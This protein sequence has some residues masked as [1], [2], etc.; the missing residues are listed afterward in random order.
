MTKLS[1]AFRLTGKLS[2]DD[3]VYIR[4]NTESKDMGRVMN[5]ASAKKLFQKDAEVDTISA[6]FSKEGNFIGYEYVLI[7]R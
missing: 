2:D 7:G 5:V 4:Y 6:R 1:E 3:A